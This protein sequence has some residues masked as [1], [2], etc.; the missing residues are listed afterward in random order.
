MQRLAEELTLGAGPQ[1]ILIEDATG[2]GK[3]EAALLLAARMIEA[4]LGEGVYFALP[5]HGDRQ[6][7]AQTSRGGRAASCSPTI[8]ERGR[9][10]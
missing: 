7:D 5:D 10:P 9:R 2:S 8:P 1:L 3:T 6:C 4:G